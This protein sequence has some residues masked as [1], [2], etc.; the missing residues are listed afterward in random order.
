MRT[1]AG[2][3]TGVRERAQGSGR[4]AAAAAARAHP[5]SGTPAPAGLAAAG[6]TG[7]R[8]LRPPPQTVSLTVKTNISI[9]RNPRRQ[10]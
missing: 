2:V 4:G 9:S 3:E 1:A 6:C 10:H 5:G 7:P 8:P